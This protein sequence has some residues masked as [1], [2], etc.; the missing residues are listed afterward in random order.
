MATKNL[1][2]V[3]GAELSEN[4]NFIAEVSG[5]INRVPY[6]LI[7]NQIKAVNESIDG[8]NQLL[9]SHGTELTKLQSQFI[10]A[11]TIEDLKF[12]ISNI[13][14]NKTCTCFLSANC[15]QELTSNYSVAAKGYV[16][17]PS[18]SM[19]DISLM[20]GDQ[21]LLFGRYDTSLSLF[22]FKETV[23]KDEY[24]ELSNTLTTLQGIVNGHT[25]DINTAT[26][27]IQTNTE[28]IQAN[29]E[30]IAENTTS[31]TELNSNL[32]N[33]IHSYVTVRHFNVN[34]AAKMIIKLGVNDTVFLFGRDTYNKTI[35]ASLTPSSYKNLGEV[36][37]FSNS[38]YTVTCELGNYSCGVM[39]CCDMSGT[40]NITY[41]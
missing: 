32:G 28:N 33:K 30:A 12:S 27:N 8:L 24:L 21:T 31:I 3:P 20:I 4:V 40:L 16:S 7:E 10:Y 17:K 26:Q 19:I 22:S 6:S 11:D 36:G 38:D 29:T 23:N 18:D 13:G 37:T 2:T 34:Q 35:C 25:T 1:T 15:V 5:D 14:N 9:S 39:I 41:Q